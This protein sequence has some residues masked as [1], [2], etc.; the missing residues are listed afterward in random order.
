[1]MYYIFRV[2]RCFFLFE[3]LWLLNFLQ[4]RGSVGFSLFFFR[5]HHQVRELRQLS[6]PSLCRFHPYFLYTFRS[7]YSVF[8][9]T[10]SVQY[11]FGEQNLD[12]PLHL[13]CLHLS[14]C[15]VCENQALFFIPSYVVSLLVNLTHQ[16]QHNCR[17]FY[18]I[19]CFYHFHCVLFH[20]VYAHRKIIDPVVCYCHI[21]FFRLV[22]CTFNNTFT[23]NY[24][25]FPKTFSLD[26][27]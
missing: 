4:C 15:L 18:S 27:S 3:Q 7:Q 10:V 14:S 21:C 24:S 25:G 1:M 16:F 11:S 13:F 23:T 8:L 9:I 5:F 22:V 6:F 2:N 20:E 12:D 17:P 26:S 19:F